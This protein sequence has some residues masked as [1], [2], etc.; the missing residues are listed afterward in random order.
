VDNILLI[1]LPLVELTISNTATTTTSGRLLILPLLNFCYYCDAKLVLSLK[2]CITLQIMCECMQP[3]TD[4]SEVRIE[5]DTAGARHSYALRLPVVA[6][7]FMEPAPLSA[8]D[9]A[10]RWQVTLL[11]HT[12]IT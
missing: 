12:S 2:Y 3:F 1:L 9:F 5:F 8:D 7:S 11:P 4:A 10:Q 6:T